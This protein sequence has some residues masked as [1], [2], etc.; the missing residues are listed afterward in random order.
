MRSLI[1]K[2]SG[3]R[4]LHRVPRQIKQHSGLRAKTALRPLLVHAGD[5]AHEHGR[6]LGARGARPR[7]QLAGSAVAG[8]QTL[9]DRP[10]HGLA[11]PAGGGAGVREGR[12]DAGR[13][14][15]SQPR[16]VAHQEDGQLLAGDGLLA[17]EPGAV[18]VALGDALGRA[19]GR[20]R[21]VPVGS[22]DV[23]EALGRGGL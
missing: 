18:A 12:L 19:P 9:G 15:H 5:K 16:G 1:S 13:R 11:G 21:G 22:V 6:H 4:R 2:N 23:L 7:S 10:L 8:E 20:G 17:A 3:A 14:V